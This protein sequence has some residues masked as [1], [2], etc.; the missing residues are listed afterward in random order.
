MKEGKRNNLPYFTLKTGI[1]SFFM[2]SKKCSK[3]AM[4]CIQMADNNLYSGE[5]SEQVK[6]NI[7]LHHVQAKTLK[8]DD[9]YGSFVNSLLVIDWFVV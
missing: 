2:Y 6:L 3:I 8:Y 7:K 1:T 5:Q 9:T 4:I